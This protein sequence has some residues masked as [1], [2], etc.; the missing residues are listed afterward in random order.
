MNI[1]PVYNTGLFRKSEPVFKSAFTD[2]GSGI[3]KPRL[4][5]PFISVIQGDPDYNITVSF[6]SVPSANSYR[7]FVDGIQVAYGTGTTYNIEIDKNG[8]HK[9]TVR[10]YD[11]SNAFSPSLHSNAVEVTV[12]DRGIFLATLGRFILAN[13]KRILIR[14]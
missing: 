4:A 2:S 1:T 5:A 7:V 10:A 12:T 9:I 6:A 11:S 3:S 14:K 8:L 13:A